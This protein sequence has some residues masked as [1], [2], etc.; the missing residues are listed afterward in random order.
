LRESSCRPPRGALIGLVLRR[1]GWGVE[2]MP[3]GS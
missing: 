2:A 1:A 3:S